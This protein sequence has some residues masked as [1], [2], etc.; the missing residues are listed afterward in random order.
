MESLVLLLVQSIHMN[1]SHSHSE[2]NKTGNQSTELISALDLL[3]SVFDAQQT[4]YGTTCKQTEPAFNTSTEAQTKHDQVVVPY[5]EYDVVM[6]VW[7]FILIH[8]EFT[9]QFQ[10]NNVIPEAIKQLIVNFM[11]KHSL[12]LK[13][14][15]DSEHK[16]IELKVHSHKGHYK[17]YT[18]EKMLQSNDDCYVA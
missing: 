12:F 2:S 3:I 15:N 8:M 9:Q 6:C 16:Q 17:Q 4:T 11:G 18:P 10:F 14:I 1:N 13:M 7:G 5:D